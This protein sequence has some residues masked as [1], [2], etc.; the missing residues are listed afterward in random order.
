MRK[1]VRRRKYLA[2]AATALGGL[3]GC[4]G[5][6][7]GDSP[8]TRER[9]PTDKRTGGTDG[10]SGGVTDPA[11]TGSPT[12]DATATPE[13]GTSHWSTFRGDPAR[14]GVRPLDA[15]PGESFAVSWTVSAADLLETFEDVDPDDVSPPPRTP[16]TSWPVLTRSAVVWTVG[17]QWTDPDTDDLATALRVI[18]AS[19]DGTIQWSHD[20]DADG[21]PIVDS[22]YA[23]E[24]SDERIHVPVL[25]DEGI[26]VVALDPV[27]GTVVDRLSLGLS[28]RSSQ[29][30]VADGRL[31]VA[32][33]ADRQGHLRAFDVADGAEAWS[34]AAAPPTPG[35][36]AVT[37][38]D[39]TLW[40]FDRTD[41]RE[42]VARHAGDGAER[43]RTTLDL[44][45]RLRADGPAVLAPP[46]V[47][48]GIGYAAGDVRSLVNV[49]VAPLVASDPDGAANWQYRL[50]GLEGGDHPL[51][52]TNPDLS[53]EEVEDLPPFSAVYGYPVVV[54]GQVLA[55]GVGDPE[56]GGSEGNSYLFAVDA[57][58]G[59]LAWTVPVGSTAFAPVVAGKVVYLATTEGVEAVSTDG[60]YLGSVAVDGVLSQH[61]PA[62]GH[63]QLYVPTVDGLV[64]VG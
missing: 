48:K 53:P 32:E 28:V 41:G 43:W 31:Y 44:P 54:D 4:N 23:P 12:T 14:T 57:A 34:A 26:D 8:E 36:P 50:P 60:E 49:D 3:A 61:P 27:D 2:V 45:D 13:S 10:E 55:T 40:T 15:G 59:S 6:G 35:R 9:E 24:V 38:A 19:P 46:T 21:A 47:V 22:W 30:L 5:L 7:P 20:V 63:G 29:P 1:P 37:L 18:A 64:A 25:G 33:T 58:D 52:R 62:V 16:F 17:Y 51:V 42:F 56:D 11:T 39:G